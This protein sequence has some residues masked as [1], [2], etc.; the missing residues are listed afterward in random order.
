M[1]TFKLMTYETGEGPRAGI[2]CGE[3][4]FDVAGATGE[5]RYDALAAILA[6]WDRAKGVLGAFAA[7]AGP[8]RAGA[9]DMNRV[10]L[11]APIP[12]PGAIYC[13]GA[14]YRDH[15]LEMAKAQNIQPEP[16]PHTLGL[17]AWHFIKSSRCVAAPDATIPLPAHSKKVDW[18]AELAVVI[19]RPAKN[20][21]MERALDVVAGYT[22]GN[23]LSARDVSRRQG[24]SDTSPFKF[25]WVGQKCFDGA[26]PLGPWIVPADDVPDPHQLKIELK[27]NGVTKQSSNTSELIFNVV[28]QISH[29]SERITLHPGDVILTGTPAGVG[30]GRGEFLKRGDEVRITIERIGELVNRFS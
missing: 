22:I 15:V 28:E 12:T 13:A 19:G 16:D 26:C 14:N 23:D 6:D 4:A 5:K 1:A 17:K 3:A 8:S 24:I 25:D 29:L 9:L 27:V 2:L 11:L 7:G 30:A 21:P 10:R 18:E 20:V